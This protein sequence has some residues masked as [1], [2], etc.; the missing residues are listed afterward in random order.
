[1]RPLLHSNQSKM[2]FLRALLIN[3][4]A[5]SIIADTKLQLL[6]DYM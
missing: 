6:I 5:M 3:R 1:M 4:K 2:A